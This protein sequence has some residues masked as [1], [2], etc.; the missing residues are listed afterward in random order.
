MKEIRI[1]IL[2]LVFIC[3]VSCEADFDE[4]TDSDQRSITFSFDTSALLSD[5]LMRNQD[6]ECY[7]YTEDN[8]RQDCGLRITTYC[9][10]IKDS[11]LYSN[12][13]ISKEMRPDSL[14][15]RYLHKDTLY[16]FVFVADVVKYDP[17]VDYYEVWYQLGV[18]D[19]SNF[20]FF[21]QD[22]S[23]DPIMNAISMATYELQADNQSLDVSFIP[24]TYNG[25]CVFTE[26][27]KV[28]YI[29]GYVYSTM[30][31]EGKTLDWIYKSSKPY[32]FKHLSHQEKILVKPV[33]LPH[34][35][36]VVSISLKRIALDVIDSVMI[37]I[38]N[39]ERRPFVAQIDCST[40]TLTD[41][42]FY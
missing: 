7:L 38:P 40:C 3:F 1:K 35:D 22:R 21:S 12:S 29:S 18:K 9:Y 6:G 14:K 30:S 8:I 24:I 41:N 32:Q 2:L 27:D 10:N 20:Y 17:Y 23:E 42:K 5:V 26:L 34:V 39:K 37:E 11:L 4:L 13:S 16:R 28:D 25:Y 33:S 19:W 31:F 36:S 15:V